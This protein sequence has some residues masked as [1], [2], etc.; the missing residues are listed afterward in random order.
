MGQ[1]INTGDE[2]IRISPK[3]SGKLEVSKNDGKNWSTRYSGGPPGDFEDLTCSGDEI[4]A[5]TSK[6]LFVSKNEGRNWS[7]RHS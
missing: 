4:L 2:L 1:M 7:K 3:D 6:G 5:T